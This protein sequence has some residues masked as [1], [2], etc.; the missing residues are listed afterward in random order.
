MTPPGRSAE[1]RHGCRKSLLRAAA[2]DVRRRRAPSVLAVFLL[3][4]SGALHAQEFSLLGGV[5]RGIGEHTY[6]WAAS[7]QEGL[8]EYFAASF[9]W[10]NEGH[11]TG[12]HRDGQ[13]VQ[14]WVRL[15]LAERRLVFSA[16]I[17]PYRYFDTSTD[18]QGSSYS[19]LHGW[20]VV[21]SLRT[22]YYMSNR[23]IAQ[24]QLNRVQVQRGPNTNSAMIGVAYQ[25]DAPDVPG[26][27]D[28]APSR[29]TRV[30]GNEVT[31]YLGETVV[32]STDSETSLAA[33]LE[34]R[35]GIAKY[36]DWTVGYVH[37]G[38]TNLVRRDGLTTQLWATRAFF[39]DRLT[40]GLGAGVYFAVRQQSNTDV[41][42]DNDTD[43]RFAG[44][45]SM[46]ASYRFGE[47]WTTRVTWNRIVTRYN[48]DTD[49][50][51]AGVGYRF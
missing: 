28:W 51:L 14:G 22:Q 8:G 4:A 21:Y 48:R 25:L 5:A 30:T 50:I 45:V 9:T 34:Y 35:R 49:V 33:A 23:W 20:G 24:L 37:E 16:G 43:D 42:G 18:Q 3:T 12:H 15:P 27:R 1:K 47:H 41:T 40:L 2:A 29:S 17:G 31:A 26:P 10:L 39:D 6:T 7:Y 46:S 36:F 13:L 32:N 38:N 44:I 19:D 11:V